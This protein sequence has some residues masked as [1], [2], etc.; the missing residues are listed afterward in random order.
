M[1]VAEVLITAASC[2]LP[3]T[4][5]PTKLICRTVRLRA[6]GDLEDQ[7]DAIIA[8]IDDLG[9]DADIVAPEHADRPR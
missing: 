1:L 2:R 3:N 5:L 7:V 8:A 4:V 9:L 6:F